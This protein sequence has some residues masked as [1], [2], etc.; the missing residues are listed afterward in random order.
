[1]HGHMHPDI[2]RRTHTYASILTRVHMQTHAQNAVQGIL[3]A[4]VFF[5]TSVVWFVFRDWCPRRSA[6]RSRFRAPLMFVPMG[7]LPSSNGPP[8]LAEVPVATPWFSP[9][10]AERLPAPCDTAPQRTA[11]KPSAKPFQP[12]AAT[13]FGPNGFTAW[14]ASEVPCST[15]FTGVASGCGGGCR[16]RTGVG[17]RTPLKSSVSACAHTK[18]LR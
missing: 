5:L 12:Q 6:K 16:S 10:A 8:Q 7:S 9:G 18:S 1:M 15:G 14:T 3:C 2:R 13:A 17:T 11:L 4:I